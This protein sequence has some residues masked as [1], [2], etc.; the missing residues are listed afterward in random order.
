[1][2]TNVI[3]DSYLI[4]SYTMACQG[5]KAP[6]SGA[7]MRHA[8]PTSERPLQGCKRSIRAHWVAIAFSSAEDGAG[9]GRACD[10]RALA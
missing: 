4:S 8:S 5:H 3:D 2:A 1:M 9:R 6:Q 7:L 10:G